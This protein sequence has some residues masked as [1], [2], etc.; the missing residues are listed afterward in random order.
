[1]EDKTELQGK[2]TEVGLEKNTLTIEL[3][4]KEAVQKLFATKKLF[5]MGNVNIILPEGNK[6]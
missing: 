1:M 4:G 5:R 6:R 3:S 2:I